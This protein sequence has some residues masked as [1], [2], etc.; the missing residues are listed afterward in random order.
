[1]DARDV[2]IKTI[3]FG[4]DIVLEEILTDQ[5]HGGKFRFEGPCSHWTL[6]IVEY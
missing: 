5:V 4:E 3:F 1:M 2:I 6:R